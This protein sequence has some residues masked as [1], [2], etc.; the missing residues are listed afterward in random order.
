MN[1]DRLRFSPRYRSSSSCSPIRKRKIAPPCFPPPRIEGPSCDYS[2]DQQMNHCPC[3]TYNYSPWKPYS[4]WK[5]DTNYSK[6]SSKSTTTAIEELEKKLRRERI[7]KR[8]R[9]L[10]NSPK[11]DEDFSEIS[12]EENGPILPLEV[13]HVLSEHVWNQCDSIRDLLSWN[14]TWYKKKIIFFNCY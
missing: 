9:Y 7:K 6:N 1:H 8:T 3:C 11:K 4:I 13:L 10:N 5:R 14:S 2:R 12:I